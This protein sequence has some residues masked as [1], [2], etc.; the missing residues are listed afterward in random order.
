MRVSKL[1]L[2]DGYFLVL[3]TKVEKTN[4]WLLGQGCQCPRLF[5]V[6]FMLKRRRSKLFVIF[7]C[8]SATEHA[9]GIN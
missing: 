9:R 2:F 5:D 7:G 8:S 6:N 4:I 1:V 3:L